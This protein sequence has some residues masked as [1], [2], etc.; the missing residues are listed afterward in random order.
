MAPD[1]V[2]TV[3]TNGTR[4]PSDTRLVRTTS[5]HNPRNH[6]SATR[7]ITQ[8]MI[9]AQIRYPDCAGHHQP[10]MQRPWAGHQAMAAANCQT[11][12]DMAPV[13]PRR[14]CRPS[15]TGPIATLSNAAV[16]QDDGTTSTGAVTVPVSLQPMEVQILSC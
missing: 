5:H 6:R 11:I 10:T 3:R 2:F 9:V 8:D 12:T 1:D 13:T 4:Q 15:R 14:H 16:T 7:K